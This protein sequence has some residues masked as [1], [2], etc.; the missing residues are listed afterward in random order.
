MSRRSLALAVLSGCLLAA[1]LPGPGYSFLAWFSLVPLLI[2]LRGLSVRSG[3]LLSF[4][5]GLA[6]FCGTVSWV[7]NSIHVHGRVP[8]LT[9]SIITF[10]FCCALALFFAPFGAAVVHVRTTRP[11]LVFLAAP[12]VWTALELSRT[13]LFSGFPWMLSGYSQYRMLPIIQIADVAG[14]YGISFIIVLVNISIVELISIRKRF[15]LLLTTSVVLIA[16]LAYGYYRMSAHTGNGAITVTVV[17]GNIDQD[18]K[19]DPAHQSE[20]IATYKRLTLK[21]VEQKPDLV[22]WPETATPFYFEGPHQPLTDDLRKFV[23]SSGNPLIFGSPTY[24]NKDRRLLRNSA[25]L[26][27]RDGMTKAV[28]HKV[29]LVPF[30]E[31]VPLKKSLLFFVDKIVQASEDFQAGSKNTLMMVRIRQG[32]E[33]AI[34]AVICYEIIFPGLVRGFVNSGATIMANITNDAWF[35]RTSAPYQHFSM[36]VFRAVE[37]R[38]PIARAANSGISGFIDSTGRILATSNIFTE[39]CLTRSLTPSATRTFYTRYGDVFAYLCSLAGLLLVALPL[40]E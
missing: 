4:V 22:I 31:Y 13:H 23:R 1:S 28:Y 9:A 34:G 12:A 17:Q 32:N 2:A 6:F 39:A 15:A 40:K 14:V 5:F 21:A 16:V 10:L 7:F 3:L 20:V 19:W 8:L 38:V 24:E 18:K 30:G 29:H 25:F 37:N 35:G 11:G 36:A 33:V 26:L 27:D